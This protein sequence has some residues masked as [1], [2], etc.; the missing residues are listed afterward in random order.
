[1]QVP[2]RLA[3]S[4]LP[5]EQS[6]VLQTMEGSRETAAVCPDPLP[7]ANATTS[8]LATSDQNDSDSATGMNLGSIFAYPL[9]NLQQV[10][11]LARSVVVVV[12]LDEWA[13]H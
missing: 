8:A 5:D 6:L 3:R 7:C 11:R 13:A 12:A 2:S 9:R 1:M 10:R 4:A